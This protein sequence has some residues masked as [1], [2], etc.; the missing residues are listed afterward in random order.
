MDEPSDT[1]CIGDSTDARVDL[2]TS[3]LDRYHLNSVIGYPNTIG[4]CMSDLKHWLAR[5]Q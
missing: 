3:V 5:M 1:D 4:S 2:C